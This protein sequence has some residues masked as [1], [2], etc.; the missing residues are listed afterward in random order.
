MTD[1]TFK[2]AKR[3]QEPIT[4]E[5]E[6]DDH[7][8]AFTAPKQAAMVLPMMEQAENGL[9]ATRAAFEWLDKGLSTEDQDRIT[10]R[11]KDPDDDFDVDSLEEIVVGLVEAV[12][13]RPTT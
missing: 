10:N 1:L 12:G 8:Y 7:V 3:R 11:L 6:G 2:V 4:F 13:A 9:M 5:I